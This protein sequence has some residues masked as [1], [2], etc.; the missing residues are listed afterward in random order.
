MAFLLSPIVTYCHVRAKN[1][2]FSAKNAGFSKQNTRLLEKKYEIIG[3][4]I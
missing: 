1:Q 4:K 3:G 2:E